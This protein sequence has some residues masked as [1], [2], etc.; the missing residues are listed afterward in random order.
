MSTQ[1]TERSKA[2]VLAERIAACYA[3]DVIKPVFTPAELADEIVSRL[4]VGGSILVL[5][6]LGLLASVL[7]RLKADGKDRSQVTFVAHTPEQ[8]AF[9]QNLAVKTW[10]VGYNEP[11]KYLEKLCMGLKFDIIVGNPPYQNG[12]DAGNFVLWPKFLFESF[13]ALRDQGHMAFVVPQTWTMNGT[14]EYKRAKDVSLIRPRVFTHGHLQWVDL[15][16]GKYFKVA[17]T[18]SAF[19]FQKGQAGSTEIVTDDGV[20]TE[21]Y[22]AMPWIPVMGSSVAVSILKKTI[23]SDTPK[24]QLINGGREFSGFRVGH[25]NIGTG[26]FKIVNTSAQYTRG[27]FLQSTIEHPI[28]RLKKVI[29]SDSGYAS[30]FF[31]DGQLGLGHHARAIQVRSKK[32]AERVINI[33]NSKLVRFL[34]KT[35]PTTGSASAISLIQ[36]MLPNVDCGTS[37]VELYEHFKLTQDEIDLIERTVK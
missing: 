16:V 12:G 2:L 1:P 8:E 22:T 28:Q 7:K 21:D 18:F 32:D 13:G 34:G 37:D 29:F 11:I 33:L 17:S 23:W 6:D 26:D 4:P 20:Y 36:D 15:T 27:Q 14:E 31:D 25:P 3:L 24:F 5:S 30:P 9:S 10:Q 19:V 35:K